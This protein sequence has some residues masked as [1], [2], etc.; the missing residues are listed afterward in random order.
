MARFVSILIAM[1]FVS[2]S[3]PGDIVAIEN[4][5][6]GDVKFAQTQNDESNTPVGKLVASGNNAGGMRNS[7]P[8]S[9]TVVSPNGGESWV[10]GSTQTTEWKSNNVRRV[11][12]W[13][14]EGNTCGRIGVGTLPATGILNAGSYTFTIGTDVTPFS[15]YA[16]SS[17][18]KIR[19]ASEDDYPASTVYDDSDAP[20]SIVEDQRI[21]NMIPVVEVVPNR[22]Y[23]Y[24]NTNGT[25][26]IFMFKITVPPSTHNEWVELRSFVFKVMGEGVRPGSL[27]LWAYY[28]ADMTIPANFNFVPYVPVKKYDLVGGFLSTIEPS[29]GDIL[30]VPRDGI[31]YFSLSADMWRS[32]ATDNLEVSLSEMNFQVIRRGQ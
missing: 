27:Q 1:F 10:L 12:L 21:F 17:I 8:P 23:D 4:A 29:P 3:I 15:V 7:R 5:S 25:R 19:V 32:Q 28:D 14:C 16:P 9:I 22:F 24:S 26:T 11:S 13:L 31:R 2:I 18:L 6:W 20:F 30:F